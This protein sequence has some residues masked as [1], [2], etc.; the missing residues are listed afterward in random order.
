MM[1][2]SHMVPAVLQ[3]VILSACALVVS[4]HL[5]SNAI[6]NASNNELWQNI[7]TTFENAA[8]ASAQAS[9]KG[10]ANNQ[11]FSNHSTTFNETAFNN[12]MKG[13]FSSDSDS[14]SF[15]L[16]TLPRELF[17][18][19]LLSPLYYYWQIWLERFLPGRSSVTALM[20]AGEKSEVGE[21][22]SREEEIVQ[23]W[24]AQGKVRRASLSWWNTF[25]KWV[26]N[27]TVGT[28]WI[29]TLRHLLTEII[30]GKSPIKVFKTILGLVNSD[31]LNDHKWR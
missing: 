13:F 6:N 28:L 16:K 26:L 22:D 29:E 25:V 4:H 1:T 30:A 17:L 23:K 18:L 14:E 8:N 12:S 31:K 9:F 7:T 21:G 11:T 2:R 3:T 24:I 27:L 15:Y 5:L 20:P 19:I 10:K